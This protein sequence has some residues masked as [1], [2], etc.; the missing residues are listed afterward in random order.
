MECL[1]TFNITC[2]ATGNVLSCLSD[3]VTL[4]G[5]TSCQIGG[6]LTPVSCELGWCVC[7]CVCA[8]VCVC[9]CARA[10][11]CACVCVCSYANWEAML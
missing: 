6:N 4:P 5:M 2:S 10:C 9:V 1:R 11:V 3:S 7:V 8:C